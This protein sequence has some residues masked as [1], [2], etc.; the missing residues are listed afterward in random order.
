VAGYRSLYG[1]PVPLLWG[2]ASDGEE[3]EHVVATIKTWLA[4]DVAAPTI[5]VLARRTREQERARIALK[6]AGIPVELLQRDGPGNDEAVKVSSMHRAKGTEYERVIVTGAAEG[7]VP[8]DFV[9][10]GKP[11]AEHAAIRGRER[12]LFYVACSRA[13][14]QLLV[15]WSGK[16]SP[17]IPELA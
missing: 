9:F 2:F 11:D 7:V 16:P 15:T 14:E 1:G 17:F 13:R 3:I 4:A 6:D 5:A 10:E 8:L 12:S